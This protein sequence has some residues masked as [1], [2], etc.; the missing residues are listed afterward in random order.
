LPRQAPAARPLSL[1]QARERLTAAPERT[2]ARRGPKTSRQTLALGA[3]CYE[4]LARGTLR[5]IIC[6]LVRERFGRELD[7]SDVTTYARRYA[8]NPDVRKPWPV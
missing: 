2:H 5:R 8:T 3:F 6:R 1:E 4:R 7:E